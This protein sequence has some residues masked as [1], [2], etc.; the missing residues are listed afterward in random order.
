MPRFLAVLPALAAAALLSWTVPAQ[1]EPVHGLAGPARAPSLRLGSAGVFAPDLRLDQPARYNPT[2]ITGVAGTAAGDTQTVTIVLAG[3][4]GG[5]PMEFPVPVQPDGTFRYST[6]GLTD[7][8]EFNVYAYQ[9]DSAGGRTTSPTYLFGVDHRAPALTLTGPDA[10]VTTRRPR[11]TGTTS[12]LLPPNGTVTL[13]ISPGDAGAPI[14]FTTTPVNGAFGV[15]VPGDLADGSYTVTATQTD[16]AGNVGTSAPRAFTVAAAGP[17]VTLTGPAAQVNTA[18]P[19]ISGA[20]TADGTVTVTVARATGG[21]VATFTTTAAD[22]VFAGEVPSTL[23]DGAYTAT[24]AVTTSSGATASSPARSFTV[25]T[26]PPRSAN[27]NSPRDTNDATPLLSGIA[28]IAAGDSPALTLEIRRADAVVQTLTV[29]LTGFTFS[30]E[31]ATLADGAY[32]LVVRQTDAAGNSTETTREFVVDTVAPMID[33][34]AVRATYTFGEVASAVFTCTDGGTGVNACSGPSTVDTS[35]LGEHVLQVVA[36]DEVGNT[37]QAVARY[38]VTDPAPATLALTL[39]PAPSLGTILPGTTATYRTQSTAAV[40]A[41]AAS[42]LRVADPSAFAT[43]RLQN[44]AYALESP[45]AMRATTAAG[46]SAG[47]GTTVTGPLT[48]L[49]YAAPVAE[50]AVT[51]A[52]EQPVAA[53]EDLRTGAYGKVFT[54]TLASATP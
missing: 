27:I 47:T 26:T 2:A 24:A 45:L 3:T 22:G 40:T 36:K 25:D 52:F 50:D 17:D 13:T 34:S 31:A 37:S 33:V 29:P 51:L 48:L 44:G 4:T 7:N 32:T 35:T 28:G 19:R 10:T 6:A 49:S 42:V 54:L 11:I 39:G 21:T 15:D 9:L 23:P 18:R 5:R 46:A 20:T 53:Q 8:V 12:E 16:P 43:G 38:T 14:A 1:A 41:P 30:A